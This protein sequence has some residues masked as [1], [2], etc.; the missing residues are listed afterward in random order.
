MRRQRVLRDGTVPA[1]VNDRVRITL[2]VRLQG[3]GDRVAAAR[4]QE[5]LQRDDAFIGDPVVAI[6][7]DRAGQVATLMPE[8]RTLAD[9]AQQVGDEVGRVNA[10]AR[11][12]NAELGC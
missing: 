2:A 6:E 4:I 3:G 7:V 9:L 5:I 8:L 1:D 11:R 12:W 10:L